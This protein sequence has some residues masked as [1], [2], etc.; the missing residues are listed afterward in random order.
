MALAHLLRAYG[1]EAEEM[2]RELVP[3]LDPREVRAA[4]LQA[5]RGFNSPMTSSV[6]RLFDAVSALLGICSETTYTGQPAVELEMAAARREFPPYLVSVDRSGR[7]W[8]IDPAPIIR[9]VVEDIRAGV[10]RA[11]IAARFH[12]TV[13]ALI[14]Q[15]CE[16][17]SRETGLKQ[18]A[19]GGGVFQNT[20]LLE[21]LA[22]ML[23][24][25]GLEPVLHSRAPTNDGG[26]ALGQAVIAAAREK[27][28]CV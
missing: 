16:Q 22:E 1:G 6:G 19:L 24:R 5:E 7:P 9:G 17:M 28:Q 2:A 10:D 4:L 11:E 23:P 3:D 26:L 13:A 8:H 15:V 21:L 12:H 20:Y 14:A 25:R 18:V 27:R